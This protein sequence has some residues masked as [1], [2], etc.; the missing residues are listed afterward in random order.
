MRN[1]QIILIVLFLVVAIVFTVFFFY[2]RLMVDHNA[3][4]ITCDGV[5]LTVSVNASDRELCAGLRAYDDVDGDISDRIIVRRVS[6]LSGANAASIYYAVFDSSSNVCTFSRTV[7]YTDYCRPHFSLSQPLSFAPGSIITLT[8]RLSA[9]DVIDGDITQKIRVA[10]SNIS[11]GEPGEYRLDVQ[12]TNSSGDT[13]V[14]S[15]TVLIESTTSRHPTIALTKYLHYVKRGETLTQGDLRDLIAG[16]QDSASGKAVDA[17]DITITGEVDTE[18]YGSYPVSYSYTNS[19]GLTCTVIL[20]V[21][22]E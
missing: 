5:P 11:T 3:P 20:T 17:E 9:S 21:V 19:E 10:S 4:Q 16:A 2:D 14:A 8:D 18:K 7:N 1:L 13:A 6:Q 12:V 15:L 22:V